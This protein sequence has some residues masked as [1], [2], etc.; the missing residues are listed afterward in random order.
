M[1]G[2]TCLRQ[3]E[4]KMATVNS[5]ASV[6]LDNTRPITQKERS[7]SFSG[8]LSGENNSSDQSSVGLAGSI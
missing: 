6:G 1:Q 3:E 7:G 8:E 2:P 5:S 4:D